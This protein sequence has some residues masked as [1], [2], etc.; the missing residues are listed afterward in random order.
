MKKSLFVF[1]FFLLFANS[2]HPCQ[3]DYDCGYGNKCVKPSGSYSL[4]GNCVV[5]TNQFGQQDYKAS[6]QGWGSGNQ[7]AQVRSCQFN[8]D[9]GVGFRCFK[10]DGQIYGLCSK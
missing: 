6:Y 8:T 3:T 2:A 10:E 1:T 7:P 5:M 4:E 9:C